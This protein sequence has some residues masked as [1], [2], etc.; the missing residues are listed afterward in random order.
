MNE[1]ST[2]VHKYDHNS[3]FISMITHIKKCKTV[4][5]DMACLNSFYKMV[6]D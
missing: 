6:N 3:K 2:Y 5:T 4:N 1:S